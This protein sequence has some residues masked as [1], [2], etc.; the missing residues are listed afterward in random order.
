M[1]STRTALQLAGEP[2][3]IRRALVTSVVVGTILAIVNHGGELLGLALPVE[4][5]WPIALTYV[6]PYG[7]STISSI[8]AIQSVGEIPV[9]GT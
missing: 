9:R 7:V 6:V 2:R 1:R 5:L 4:K 3:V 8:G